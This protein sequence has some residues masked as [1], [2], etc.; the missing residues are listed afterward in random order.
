MN[1]KYYQNALCKLNYPQV[2]KH[3]NVN[4][5]VDNVDKW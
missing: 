4:K 3:K 2:K 1:L 5:S